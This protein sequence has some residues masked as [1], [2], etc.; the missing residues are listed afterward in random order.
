[1]D[2]SNLIQL[3]VLRIERNKP[4][5]CVCKVRRFSID[6]KNREVVCD[7]GLWVDPFEAILE[8]ATMHERVNEQYKRMYEQMIQW[9]K[10]KPRSVIFKR[11]ERDYR[12]GTM[13]PACPVCDKSFDFA[14]IVG[15][16]HRDHTKLDYRN[17]S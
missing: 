11:L 12:K 9:Q 16:R 4:R 1:M 17:K 3:D 10:E 8:M 15:W 13:L 5:K 7:C 14:D 6:T 2:E